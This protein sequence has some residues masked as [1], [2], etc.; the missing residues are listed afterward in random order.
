L[1]FALA[2]LEGGGRHRVDAARL[3]TRDYRPRQRVLGV[4]L[5]GGGEAEH[6]GLVGSADRGKHGLAFGER[7]RLVEDHDVEISGPFE[8]DPVFD[9]QSVSGTDRG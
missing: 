8:R 4:C 5:H 9:Q 7:P 1:T 3:C 6:L 2:P